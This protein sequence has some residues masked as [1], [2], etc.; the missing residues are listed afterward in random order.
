MMDDI[1]ND[2]CVLLQKGADPSIVDNNQK[3]CADIAADSQRRDILEA[4]KHVATVYR[5]P[6]NTHQQQQ[7]AVVVPSQQPTKAPAAQS[8]PETESTQHQIKQ[9]VPQDA[10]LRIDIKAIAESHAEAEPAAQTSENHYAIIVSDTMVTDIAGRV[11]IFLNRFCASR[12][13]LAMFVD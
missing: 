2:I 9:P 1:N 12:R 6:S 3:T 11:L 4:V 10:A 13:I 5:R 8:A 7:S